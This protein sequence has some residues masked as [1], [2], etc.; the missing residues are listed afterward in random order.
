MVVG[1]GAT[2]VLKIA[3]V[4]PEQSVQA[5]GCLG[6][7]TFLGHFDS[8]SG[9]FPDVRTFTN[10]FRR[11][12]PKWHADRGGERSDKS[13]EILLCRKCCAPC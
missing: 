2:H 6:I 11:S 9:A 8:S 10:L 5:S 13:A 3:S 1:A 4:W 12:E 7:G